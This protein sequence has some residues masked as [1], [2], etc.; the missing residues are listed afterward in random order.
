MARKGYWI[1]LHVSDADGMVMAKYAE[2]ARPVIA[3][4][5]G[6]LIIR[7]QPAKACEGGVNEPA[8]VVEF[9]NLEKAL[10]TYEDAGYQA[11]LKILDG[12]V[13]R[14]FRIVEGV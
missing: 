1:V 2:A 13:K 4:A 5:G 7:G 8:I 3:A 9:E 11:A 14:D 12:K 6:R 10:A